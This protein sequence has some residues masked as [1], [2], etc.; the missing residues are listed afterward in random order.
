MKRICVVIPYKYNP[1]RRERVARL[2][3]KAWAEEPMVDH[4]FVV[5]AS[6]KMVLDLH[7][8]EKVTKIMVPYEGNFNLPFLRNVGVRKAVDQGYLYAQIMD[9]DIFPQSQDYLKKCLRSMQRVQMVRPFVVNS[10]SAVPNFETTSELEYQKF[11]KPD[12]S[13][14][15]RK[16]FSYST[17]FMNLQVPRKIHGWD[18]AYEVWGAE[19]DDFLVRASRAGFR[20]TNLDGPMLVHSHH[21]SDT[22]DLAKKKSDQYQKNYNR[23]RMTVAGKLPQI[24]MPHDWG[25]CKKPRP[26]T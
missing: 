15:N 24:R 5:D 23:F 14:C 25:L 18:E 4:V 19:D 26:Q 16:V 8:S 12:L 20:V 6:P 9:S 1:N 10:P 7:K 3:V 17:M 21:E 13:K 22:C 11:L 2:C